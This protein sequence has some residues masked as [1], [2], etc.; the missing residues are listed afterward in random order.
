M[1]PATRVAHW[2]AAGA[3]VL[4]SVY[5]ALLIVG[6]W[7][8]LRMLPLVPVFLLGPTVVV[9]MSALHQLTPPRRRVWS[10]RA[11]SFAIIYAVLA[12]MVYYLQLTVVRLNTPPFSAEGIRLLRLSP[13]SPTFPLDMLCYTF[14]PLSTWT[15]APALGNGSETQQLRKL[16]ILHGMLAIPTVMVPGLGIG[17]TIS[18][19]GSGEL[20]GRLAMLLWCAIFV[21]MAAALARHLRIKGLREG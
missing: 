3:A 8:P 2:A 17:T 4:V 18:P 6:M 9:L 20:F 7:V 10:Q 11:L 19:G 14:L 13:G 21:P 1:Q 15:L 16:L 5:G 12:T